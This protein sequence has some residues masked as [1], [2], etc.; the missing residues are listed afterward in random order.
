MTSNKVIAITGGTGFIGK[1]LLDAHIAN[2]D[3][4]RILSRNKKLNYDNVKFFQGDLTIPGNEKILEEF[5]QGV[6]ILYHCAG[7]L[8]KESSMEDLHVLGTERLINS[9]NG[10]VKRW[11]QLSS[12]GA[13]GAYRE[14]IINSHLLDN[15]NGLYETTKSQS[16]K[17]VKNSGIDFVILRPS[18][19][20]GTSMPNHSLLKLAEIIR[21]KRFFYIGHDAIANYVEV[22]DVV[23]AMLLCGKNLEASG[24][25]YILSNNINL[26]HMIDSL[27]EGLGVK[28]PVLHIPEI[29]I[30][31]LV[32]I[33]GK[34]KGFP[35]TE[36][37]LNALT[38][39]CYYDS[40]AIER[41]LGFSFHLSIK[42]SFKNYA[43]SIT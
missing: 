22:K 13:Y 12:V 36:S 30:R 1:L 42:E 37:R 9:A 11:V 15:P 26:E 25:T 32:L 6:D 28:A 5:T 20:F 29:I 39:K 34:F 14:G 3:D 41:E 17:L 31:T 21:Q 40:S 24:K 2:K 38:K 33:L 16:D 7:E 19:V 43:K 35:L 8:Y 4:V 27:A 10:R 18:I 23:N